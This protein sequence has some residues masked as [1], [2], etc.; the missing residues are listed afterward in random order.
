MVSM[1][2]DW[3][4]ELARCRDPERRLRLLIELRR[5]VAE[6]A[7]WLDRAWEWLD[8][9]PGHPGAYDR[10]TQLIVR[11][12]LYERASDAVVREERAAA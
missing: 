6:L 10:E 2:E 3:I 11:L 8:R 9:N 1:T 5:D 12:R 7:T 4:A